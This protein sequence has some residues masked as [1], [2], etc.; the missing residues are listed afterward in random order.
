MESSDAAARVIQLS[1]LLHQLALVASEPASANESLLLPLGELT[2]DSCDADHL[3]AAVE[4]QKFRYRSSLWWLNDPDPTAHFAYDPSLIY[5]QWQCVHPGVDMYEASKT[6]RVAEYRLEIERARVRKAHLEELKRRVR[7]T[8]ADPSS[9]REQKRVASHALYDFKH[10]IPSRLQNNGARM[11]QQLRQ[12][13][14]K[15]D[16]V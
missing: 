5:C 10:R 7:V 6:A 14:E 15:V 4:G 13:I 2:V 11:R 9:T 1:W 12:Q 16:K 3:T 8:D